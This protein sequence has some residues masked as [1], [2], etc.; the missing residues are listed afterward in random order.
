MLA[1][2][3][4]LLLATS[5]APAGEPPA[6]MRPNEPFPSLL[7]AAMIP[8]GGSAFLFTGGVPFLS[9][10]YAQGL[11]DTVDAGAQLELDWLTSELF[12]GGTLRRFVGREGDLFVAVR[13][14]AGALVNGGADWA[15]AQNRSD[16]GLQI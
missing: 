10:S 8:D 9:A 5:A 13:G 16:V 1:A 15:V 3:A 12:A 11:S 2:A 4:A 7:S 6:R 14:R